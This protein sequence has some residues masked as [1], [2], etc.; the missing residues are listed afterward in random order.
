MENYSAIVGWVIALISISHFKGSEIITHTPHLSRYVA[1]R[2][3]MMTLEKEWS[4]VTQGYALQMV[5]QDIGVHDPGYKLHIT[6]QEYFPERSKIFMLGQPH[7]GCMGEVSEWW[8]CAHVPIPSKVMMMIL[9]VA[10][11]GMMVLRKVHI[12]YCPY[13]PWTDMLQT[14][15]PDHR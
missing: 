5:V 15:F 8:D 1:V 10:G 12:V 7:Y 2:D 11:G 13:N 6:P 9:V 14:P 4:K 3:G